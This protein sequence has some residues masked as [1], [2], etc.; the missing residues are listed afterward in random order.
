[1]SFSKQNSIVNEAPSD[2]F[3]S[4]PHASHAEDV[5]ENDSDDPVLAL[6]LR[7]IND[8]GPWLLVAWHR[9]RYG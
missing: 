5:L 7:L 2:T 8:V 3:P 6:K 1:M 9:D 4:S